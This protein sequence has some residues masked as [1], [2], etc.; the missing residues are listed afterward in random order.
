[1][2]AEGAFALAGALA[3]RGRF[4]GFDVR[5]PAHVRGGR[6]QARAGAPRGRLSKRACRSLPTAS[7]S[8]SSS[9]RRRATSTGICSRTS[10][11]A[12]RSC[13]ITPSL[14]T[15]RS[16]TKPACRLP[17][18]DPVAFGDL[19]VVTAQVSTTLLGPGPTYVQVARDSSSL[20]ATISRLWLF[21]A[22]GVAGGAILAT[23]AGPRS[24]GPRDGPGRPLSPKRP[25]RSPQPATRAAR[26]PQ[27][28]AGDE[29]AELATTLDEMLRELDAAR[30][31]AQGM[32]QAQREFVADASHELRTPLTSIL[33]NLE[34]L[35]HCAR[36]GRHRRERRPRWSSR[37]CARRSGCAAWSA[38]F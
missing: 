25:A 22:V 28:G 15:R 4:R 18:P 26:M 38:T 12:T 27:S 13:R 9:T 2:D 19:E 34:L 31:E 5:D 36:D 30:T 35:Q 20:D 37:P 21:L 7:P 3:P 11:S 23:L 6:R 29:V 32:V 17:I 16:A 1:M 8:P 10:R 14:G 24:R 33:A